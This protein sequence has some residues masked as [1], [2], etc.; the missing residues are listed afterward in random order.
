MKSNL[1]ALAL[2]LAAPSLLFATLAGW[3]HWHIPAAEA[4]A[5]SR[6]LELL[7]DANRGLPF[8]TTDYEIAG[9]DWGS[10]MSARQHF[11]D[12]ML[13]LCL[14][15]GALAVTAFILAAAWPKPPRSP[16]TPCPPP[17]AH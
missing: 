15:P 13:S 11:R 5:R 9:A 2:L 4:A 6:T 12:R 17:P 16:A 7:P 10:R 8:A 1:L 3:A 14:L